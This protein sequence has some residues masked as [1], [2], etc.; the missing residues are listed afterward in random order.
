MQRLRV[1]VIGA[2]AVGGYY[3]AKL[4]R[5][6]H[7]VH[8]VARGAHLQAIEQRGLMVWSPLG[9]FVVRPSVTSNPASIGAV[10]LVLFAV[11]TY[12]T[13][14]ALTLLPPLLAAETMVL[15]LQNGVRS[16]QDVG[17]VAGA[18]A[19]LAGPTYIATALAGPGF[20]EQ[21][22]SHR[23]IVFGE[24]HVSESQPSR[25][26]Q[27][28]ADCLCQADIQAEGVGDARV[29]LWSKFIYLAPFAAITGA[30][31]QPAGVVWSDPHLRATFLA[32]VHETLAV[33]RAEQ[34]GVPDDTVGQIETYMD[35]LPASTR[36]S[37]LI[38][39]SAGRPLENDALAGEVIRRGRALGVP[40]PIM[41]TLHAVLEPWAGGGRPEGYGRKL[42]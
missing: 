1:A 2:G 7:D 10:D 37:L 25:R 19:V 17:M 28:L 14:A 24:G 16:V 41:D 38:D 20:I 11:K 12:D 29:P 36:S 42:R 35:A 34:V 9:D 5:A 26:V 40:T 4:A 3:G 18:R 30:T 23:R 27:S 21:T 8:L 32:A 6:G 39:L 22:G 13:I 31:R 33:A 15:T